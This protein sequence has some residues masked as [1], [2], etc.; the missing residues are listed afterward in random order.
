MAIEHNEHQEVSQSFLLDALYCEEQEEKRGEDL[1]DD[2]DDDE[3]KSSS[4][5]PLLLLEQDL[6][7]EDE[8]LLSLFSKEKETQCCFENL[9]QS[10][11]FLCS[12]RVDDAVGWILKVNAHYGFS[13]LTAT[14]A[15]NYLNRFLSSLQY[16]KDKPWMIQLAAVTCLS[17]A[18]KVEETQVPLLLDFQVEDAKYV[19]EA[20]TI[21]R[22]E[23]LILSSLKWRMNPVT[24]LSFLDHIIRRLGLK[25]NIH[26]EFLRRCESLLLS[27]IADCRFV[28]S[29][30]SVLATAI[31]LHVI[32]QVE[33]CNAV[34]YQNQFLGVLKIS[35]EK[36]NNCF[37]LITEVSSKPIIS[38]KR[39]YDENPS[40]PSDIIDQIYSSE[41]SNDSRGLDSSSSSSSY[42]SLFK[43]SRVQE[44]Q[45]KLGSS[46]SRVVF[47]EAVGSPH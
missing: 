3:E 19:F 17:L 8:E 23:L 30:P 14:L 25:N 32:H 29:M 39:K 28:R 41:S 27:V 20:K 45:M 1:L 6:F 40:S 37:E 22:M 33:P 15:I 9:N 42:L 18:A 31:M 26:W 10:D 36:V 4:L 35:K 12:A 21:Q 2:D 38:H 13:A 5:M 24:P 16:Q 34:D 46:L 43:K 44:Q 7:W 11:T 47:V